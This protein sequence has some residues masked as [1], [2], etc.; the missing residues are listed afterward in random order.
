MCLHHIF[1]SIRSMLYQAVLEL[2]CGKICPIIHCS[3]KRLNRCNSSLINDFVILLSASCLASPTL[4]STFYL[5]GIWKL[6]NK[7]VH[8][9][10]ICGKFINVSVYDCCLSIG[11]FSSQSSV[12]SCSYRS[13]LFIFT[14]HTVFFSNQLLTA[15]TSA[16]P[17]TYTSTV[18]SIPMVP[19]PQRFLVGKE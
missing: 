3:S 11:Y 19:N 12:I 17:T 15:T 8:V 13:F 2:L 7:Y 9:I 1:K 4:F 18:S 14:S 5:L 10:I 16:T 6:K